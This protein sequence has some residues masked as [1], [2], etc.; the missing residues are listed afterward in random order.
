MDNNWHNVYVTDKTGVKMWN[1]TAS[2]MSTPSEV[3]NLSRHIEQARKHPER[4]KFL[5]V[6]TAVVMVDGQAP[7]EMSNDELLT[8]LMA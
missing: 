8:E 4:Y 1:T 5:D 6:A 3:R 7:V 2:P